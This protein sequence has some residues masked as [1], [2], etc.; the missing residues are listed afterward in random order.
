MKTNWKKSQPVYLI[1]VSFETCQ[2]YVQI[3]SNGFFWPKPQWWSEEKVNL[4]LFFCVWT[5][6]PIQTKSETKFYVVHCQWVD[7]QPPKQTHIFYLWVKI[8]F[9]CCCYWIW[10]D[11][12]FEHWLW[13]NVQLYI[14]VLLECMSEFYQC[15]RDQTLFFYF[16]STNLI[17]TEQKG[18]KIEKNFF[19]L[20]SFSAANCDTIRKVEHV[21]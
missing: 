15:Y 13:V 6:N 10:C 9:L 7:R 21:T 3:K 8:V 4:I 1:F 14:C 11:F 5:K 20:T 17:I 19:R 12:D 18:K 2:T 16:S